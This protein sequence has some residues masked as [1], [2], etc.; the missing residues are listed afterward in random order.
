[1]DEKWEVSFTRKT[2]KQLNILPN[3][4]YDI[5]FTLLRDIETYGPVRG[6]WPNF[7]VLKRTGCY[8][9]HLKKG[10]PTYVAVWRVINGNVEV[11]YVGTHEKAP[12]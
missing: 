5:V 6:D 9:C 3:R 7:G 11:I 1:M 8:H 2:H 4:I 10:N 12:Y